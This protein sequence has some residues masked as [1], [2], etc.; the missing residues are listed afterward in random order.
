VSDVETGVGR[1]GHAFGG[2]RHVFP[3]GSLRFPRSLDFN[4]DDTERFLT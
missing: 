4:A 2:R 1:V 3:V